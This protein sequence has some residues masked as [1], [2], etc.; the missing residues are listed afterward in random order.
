MHSLSSQDGL[1][2]VERLPESHGSQQVGSLTTFSGVAVLG[3]NRP[4]GVEKPTVLAQA[5]VKDRI[6]G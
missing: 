4:D 2:D 3:E 6:V 1:A 5:F